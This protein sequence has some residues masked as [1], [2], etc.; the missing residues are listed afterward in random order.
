MAEKETLLGLLE[1]KRASLISHAVT[2][3]LNPKAKLKPSGIPWLGDV[4]V[5]WDLVPLSSVISYLSYGFTNPMPSFHEGE[6][7]PLLTANDIGE[8]VVKFETARKTTR[9]AFSGLTGK[10]R[11][12]KDDILITKDGTLGRI[13][14]SD[15]TECCINQSVALLRIN[16]VKANIRFVAIALAAR[17]YQ[18]RMIF[19]AGGTTIKHIYITRLAK[20]TFALPPKAE[21]DA[22]VNYGMNSL[23]AIDSLLGSVNESITPPPRKAQ[24]PH[25]RRR[26]GG[27]G[28][29]VR[30][31]FLPILKSQDLR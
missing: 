19:E 20:M 1:E 11:P 31:L 7:V 18:D 28:G 26:D 16:P 30:P 8:G 15:G 24:L 23:A 14:V 5:H 17:A 27:D 22:L 29:V 3:G 2:R 12:L 13:A 10:C 21:Q 25:L 4:P 9:E 6:G